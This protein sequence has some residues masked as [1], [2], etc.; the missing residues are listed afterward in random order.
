MQ[1]DAVH[2]IE[3]ADTPLREGVGAAVQVPPS[4]VAASPE[5]PTSVQVPPRLHVT[6]T[7]TTADLPVGAT[8]HS[9][10]SQLPSTNWSDVPATSAPTA[11]HLRAKLQDTPYKWLLSEVAV[12]TARSSD[13]MPWWSTSTMAWA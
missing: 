11:T 10:P 8:L 9:L 4:K 6:A 1:I 12:P 7:P 2:E 5:G 3:R 13:H